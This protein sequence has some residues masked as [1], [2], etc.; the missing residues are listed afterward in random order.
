[1]SKQGTCIYGII[2]EPREKQFSLDSA[3]GNGISTIS[4]KDLAAVVSS[5]PVTSYDRFDQ[6]L[7][8]SELKT[9]QLILENIMHDHTVI[10]ISFGIIAKSENNVK[11]LLETA[12][13]D[14]K[15][16]LQEIDNKIELNVQVTCYE[17]GILNEVVSKNDTVKRLRQELFSASV[18]NTDRLKLEVGK[19]AASAFDELKGEYTN[20]ILNTLKEIAV[21][22]C[23]GKLA[24]VNMIVNESFLVD[25][26]LEATFDRKI[27]Q[28]AE[29]YEG[30]L[31]FKYIGP[32]PPYSFVSLQASVIDADT[33]DRARQV[34]SL[35]EQVTS[36]E[37]KNAYRKLANKCHP[38]KNP[39]DPEKLEQF[40]AI[41][42]AY[43]L[44]V[45]YT[46]SLKFRENG[47]Y[48]LNREQTEDSIIVTRRR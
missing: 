11:Q 46:Q 39:D 10:P 2:E 18:E 23:P 3:I 8:A 36:I 47:G 17:A 28:L 19:A 42:K 41:T 45:K 9:H 16:M 30:R 24:D 37:I 4:Y 35:G 5:T 21:N 26:R 22:S 40:K 7:V 33:I 15:D 27:D 20:D 29:K 43:E 13:V 14:F 44:L 38:D 12:Y 6:S 1:M 31:K 34:L 32:M 25:R 48:S